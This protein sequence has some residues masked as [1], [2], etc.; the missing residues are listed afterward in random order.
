MTNVREIFQAIAAKVGDV[1]MID[2]GDTVI[3]HFPYGG[4]RVS[5]ET[6]KI[7]ETGNHGTVSA[8]IA[9]SFR[10]PL[11]TG[12]KEPG[13]GFMREMSNQNRRFIHHTM[14]E[15]ERNALFGAIYLPLRG[16]EDAQ[17]IF[18]SADYM[19]KPIPV[20]QD[21]RQAADEVDGLLKK[22]YGAAVSKPEPFDG[23]LQW[24]IHNKIANKFFALH[25]KDP[26]GQPYL[27]SQI[28][29]QDAFFAHK[30][31]GENLGFFDGTNL[32]DRDFD[33]AMSRALEVSRREDFRLKSI[34]DFNNESAAGYLG[35]RMWMTEDGQVAAETHTPLFTPV[36]LEL[37]QGCDMAITTAFNDHFGWP[38]LDLTMSKAE[39]RRLAVSLLHAGF[40][41]ARMMLGSG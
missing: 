8:A 37:I 19:F 15:A 17:A 14:Y 10:S 21:W 11:P 18:D 36:T 41:I 22:F 1:Q 40:T 4:A 34:F 32:Y 5:V 26:R 38:V 31:V 9:C 39:E 3:R 2:K 16:P 12:Q 13:L 20:R 28:I 29:V 24:R 6:Q 27:A 23:M 30:A 35:M 33:Q 7:Q 25:E